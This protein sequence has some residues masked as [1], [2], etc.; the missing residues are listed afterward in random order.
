MDGMT[1]DQ[2]RTNVIGRAQVEGGGI[3]QALYRL[4]DWGISRQRYWEIPIIHCQT[5]G[6][7]PD[8]QSPVS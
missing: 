8:D 5:C 3:G 1:I 7:V 6:A 4:R 2:A